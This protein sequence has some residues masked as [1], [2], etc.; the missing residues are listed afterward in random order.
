MKK[1]LCLLM[2]V[3][4]IFSLS[5]CSDLFGAVYLS[6]LVAQGDDR[7]EKDDIISFVTEQ[8]QQLL[9]AIERGDFSGFENNGIVK[10]VSVRES[11]VEFYCGGVGM[12]SNTTYVGFFY[13]PADDMLAFY[14]SAGKED[15]F[16]VGEGF[17]WK[18]EAGDNQFYTEKIAD[19]FYYYEQS[20]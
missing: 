20:Y 8:E 7:A 3:I 2:S 15:V 6:F 1:L 19:H 4:M 12:G 11:A 17:L 14:P 5:G 18:E 9:Q 16:P 13:S 10:S